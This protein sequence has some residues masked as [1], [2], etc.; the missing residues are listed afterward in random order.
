M[1]KMNSAVSDDEAIA[2]TVET[3]KSVDQKHSHKPLYMYN[4]ES[5]ETNHHRICKIV[6]EKIKPVLSHVSVKKR[7]IFEFTVIVISI[8]VVWGLVSLPVI[9]YYTPNSKVRHVNITR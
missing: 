9:A 7:Q 3:R 1:V 6:R 5:C 2:N 4:S 8:I